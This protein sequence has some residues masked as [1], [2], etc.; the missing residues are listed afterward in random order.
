M[1]LL[2]VAALASLYFY[3]AR[4]FAVAQVSG[5]ICTSATWQWVSTAYCGP[6]STFFGLLYD[7]MYCIQTFNSLGQSPCTVTAYMMATCNGGSE[8]FVWMSVP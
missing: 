7:L 8:F 1:S 4:A 3:S 6:G 5:P 2:R